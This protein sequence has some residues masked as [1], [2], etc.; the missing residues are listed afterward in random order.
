MFIFNNLSTAS[1]STHLWKLLGAINWLCHIWCVHI[2]VWS[3][4]FWHWVFMVNGCSIDSQFVYLVSL[5]VFSM[6]NF[7]NHCRVEFL[8]HI[9][10]VMLSLHLLDD[11][12]TVTT[13]VFVYLYFIMVHFNLIGHWLLNFGCNQ[14][15]EVSDYRCKKRGVTVEF[16]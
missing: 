16:I 13:W 6:L 9:T 7:Y 11:Q 12:G 15:F 1:H 5:R 10:T 3:Y 2:R 14:W 8:L 4:P